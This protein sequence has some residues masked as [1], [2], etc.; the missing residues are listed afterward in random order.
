MNRDPN[1]AA[2]AI[3]ARLEV[4]Q[5]ALNT[6]KFEPEAVNIRCAMEGY[7][8]GAITYS[9]QH[10]LIWAGQ[11]V[12]T[13]PHYRTFTAD[14]TARLDRYF[15][16]YGPGWFY[17][18]APLKVHPTVKP[19][20]CA[21]VALKRSDVLSPLECYFVTQ[22]FWKRAK[23]VHRMPALSHALPTPEEPFFF[24]DV[25]GRV[26]CGE[27]GPKLGFRSILDSGATY[28]TLHTDDL[29]NLGVDINYYPAQSIQTMHSP[30]GPVS[31]RIYE[32]CVS[33]L[34]DEGRQL[35]D[36]NDP[37]YPY[38]HRYLGGLCPVAQTPTPLT[39]DENGLEQSFRLSGLLPFI[40]CYLSST[41][42]RNMLFLGEDRNDV[43]GSHRMPGQKKWTIE[44]DPIEPGL[45]LDRYDNPHITFSHRNG[46]IV[47]MDRAD[48][49]HASTITFL[50]GTPEEKI[51]QSDP[52][53][54]QA[55]LRSGTYQNPQALAREWE[56]EDVGIQGPPPSI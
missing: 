39:Y 48:K 54:Q 55:S 41:P 44:M 30:T 31:S 17:Y 3:K 2:T 52:G 12:D 38:N 37:V 1:P 5:W 20:L 4:L 23:F 9:T 28:P 47:D 42:S 11:I 49:T 45:P 21:S 7:K 43:L 8:S 16:T 19:K 18:E 46:R 35:V 33:V 34:D 36:E 6:S 32:L 26:Y 53:D 51:V 22:G 56:G 27:A 10:T 15:E 14:R 40:A 25:E 50:K 13:A 24:R 29:V